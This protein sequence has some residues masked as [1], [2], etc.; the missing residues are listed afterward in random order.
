MDG[1][2]CVW[3]NGLVGWVGVKG[4]KVASRRVTRMSMMVDACTPGQD[5]TLPLKFKVVIVESGANL[6]IENGRRRLCSEGFG[7]DC[8]RHAGWRPRCSS[9]GHLT[10]GWCH[11]S[12]DTVACNQRSAPSAEPVQR[13]QP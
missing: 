8:T 4:L 1:R 3:G 6:V 5:H 13:P 11:A 10:L 7:G 9:R 2:V 12:C